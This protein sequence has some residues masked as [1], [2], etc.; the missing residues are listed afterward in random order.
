MVGVPGRGGWRAWLLAALSIAVLAALPAVAASGHLLIAA[1]RD[2]VLERTL[3]LP[4]GIDIAALREHLRA[5]Y[6]AELDRAGHV[7][8]ITRK[9]GMVDR[10]EV[11]IAERRVVARFYRTGVAAHPKYAANELD[12]VLE[13]AEYLS[14]RQAS[15]SASAVKRGRGAGASPPAAWSPRAVQPPAPTSP[16]APAKPTAPRVPPAADGERWPI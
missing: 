5:G 7:I 6:A 11:D 3:P 14:R 2:A 13:V 10:I 4:A 9:Q 12:G 8:I 1:G 16:P 15:T